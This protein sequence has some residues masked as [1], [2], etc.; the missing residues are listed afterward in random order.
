MLLVLHEAFTYC[1][2]YRKVSFTTGVIG[3]VRVLLVLQEIFTSSDVTENLYVL[4]VSQDTFTCCWCHRTVSRVAG[5]TG[6][7]HVLLVLQETFTC[8]RCYK[9]LSRVID[10]TGNFD[11]LLVLQETFRCYCCYKN[12]AP[13]TL[14]LGVKA[15]CINMDICTLTP[16]TFLKKYLL[17]S[18]LKLCNVFL[19]TDYSISHYRTNKEIVITP[20]V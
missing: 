5:V 20:H 9:K 13:A 11:K 4:L 10:V 14:P 17:H 16:C 15:F 18:K 8:Y 19:R 2:Y 12:C 3:N 1:W 6:Q 7:F